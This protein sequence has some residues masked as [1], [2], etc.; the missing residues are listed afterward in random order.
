MLSHIKGKCIWIVLLS[1]SAGS[2]CFKDKENDLS[3]PGSFV[4]VD[5]GS[6]VNTPYKCEFS[7]N[8]KYVCLMH[9]HLREDG[10]E[11]QKS[12]VYDIKGNLISDAFDKKGYLT[13]KYLKMFSLIIPRMSTTYFWPQ[14]VR[15]Q[16]LTPD[17]EF[18]VNA[19]HW[20]F[21]DDFSYCLKIVNPHSAE[22][23]RILKL[24]ESGGE[25]ICTA[26]LWKIIPEKQ[27]LW[28]VDLPQ[29]L[30][31]IEEG[32]FFQ[33]GA[34]NYIL[35]AYS[36]DNSIVLSRDTGKVIYRFNYSREQSNEE[37]HLSYVDEKAYRKLGLGFSASKASFCSTNNL[38]AC[39]E[40]TGTRVRVFSLNEKG[41][42]IFENN[43]NI[44]IY[45]PRGG[46]WRVKRV[47]FAAKGKYLIADYS[48]E[49]RGTNKA[50][51]VTEIY[52]TDTWSR[53]WVWKSNN[54][55]IGNCNVIISP[56]GEK[57]ALVK[58]N[59]KSIELQIGAFKK[60]KINSEEKLFE[61]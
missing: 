4:S 58:M 18:L 6:Y 33:E 49:G 29:K 12:V 20:I 10:N 48:F 54:I 36:G 16:L 51:F 55:E 24:N 39:G 5:L 11:P 57:M 35:I 1:I 30:F 41:K 37:R 3:L 28:S 23:G 17:E 25:I 21:S 53:V 50:Y 42:L 15:K 46:A 26:E 2:G 34:N 8:N 44:D 9:L 40:G 27:L 32:G 47:E 31:D 19:R 14:D 13:Q 38:L 61:Q 56:D 7:N 43:S 52:E 59:G 22:D 45:R 60:Q